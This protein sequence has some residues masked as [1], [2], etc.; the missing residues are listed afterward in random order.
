MKT[1]K[2]F[3]NEGIEGALGILVIAI[4]FGVGGITMAS[5]DSAA[6]TVTG[7]GAL[8]NG[9]LA[10]IIHNGT[11]GILNGSL[12]IPTVGTLIGVGLMLMA[13]FMAIRY[14]RRD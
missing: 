13:L 11:N 6:G 9:T 10:R 4:L 2:G 3:I 14:V 12:Q 1:Y 8:E 7:S 5:F